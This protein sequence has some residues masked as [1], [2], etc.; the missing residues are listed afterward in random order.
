[1]AMK[2]VYPTKTGKVTWAQPNPAR[3]GE[4]LMPAD[5]T[6]FPP[7]AFDDTSKKAK[8]VNNSW[9]TEDLTPEELHEA[10]EKFKKAVDEQKPWFQRVFGF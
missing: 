5:A 9:V 8:Y 3:P 10:S 1:M 7:P 2:K 4:Y 6:E